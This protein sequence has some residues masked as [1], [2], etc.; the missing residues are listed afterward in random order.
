[1]GATVY[2]CQSL[3]F[4]RGKL[5]PDFISVMNT[6]VYIKAKAL[7]FMRGK[8]GGTAAFSTMPILFNALYITI[9]IR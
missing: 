6:Y 4:M 2:A 8:L 3:P 9:C 1:M 7:P 5:F